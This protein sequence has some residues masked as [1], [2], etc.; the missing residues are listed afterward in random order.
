[1]SMSFALIL[2]VNLIALF[3]IW[4]LNR[5]D[6]STQTKKTKT[7]TKRQKILG[8]IFIAILGV[9]LGAIHS[10]NTNL[11]GLLPSAV[12]FPVMNGGVI[13]VTTVLSKFFFKEKLTFLQI[14][15]LIVGVLS[16]ACITLADALI[17]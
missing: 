13:I 8:I 5:K 7:L 14:V 3:F 12:V 1:M 16:I 6:T 9:S 17:V 4:L 10:I 15:G 2:I 11:S